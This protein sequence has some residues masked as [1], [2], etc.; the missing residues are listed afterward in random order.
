MCLLDEVILNYITAFARRRWKE[1][2]LLDPWRGAVGGKGLSLTLGGWCKIDI[3]IVVFILGL[4]TEEDATCCMFL[5]QVSF[6]S[7]RRRNG[8]E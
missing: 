1:L 4:V 5:Q 7:R 3:T 8:G 2:G 6:S